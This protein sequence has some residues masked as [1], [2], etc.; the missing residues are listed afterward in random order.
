MSTARP[1]W[2]TDAMLLIPCPWCGPRDVTE[3]RYGGESGVSVPADT[4][5]LTDEA[6]GEFL[7][8]RSNPKGPFTERWAHA[9]GCRRWFTVR[10]D[11]S[12]DMVLPD[13][14]PAEPL[15]ELS[16]GPDRASA[17]ESR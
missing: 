10:R 8:I 14:V 12:T 1:A 9:H 4:P 15:A 6:W 13:A 17:G 2:P 16:A 7:F 11:T 5:E 3:F